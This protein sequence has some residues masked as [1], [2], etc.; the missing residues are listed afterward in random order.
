MSA[1]KNHRTK[2]LAQ[3]RLPKRTQEVSK[4]LKGHVEWL[5]E[6]PGLV[7]FPDKKENKAQINPSAPRP[8][9][10]GIAFL[11]IHGRKLRSVQTVTAQ[12]LTRAPK[13]VSKSN[14][15]PLIEEN[16]REIGRPSSG[17]K[18]KPA[19]IFFGDMDDSGSFIVR[20]GSLEI[21]S[22]PSAAAIENWKPVRGFSDAEDG[23]MF[24]DI[25]KEMKLDRDV[26]YRQDNRD[27]GVHVIMGKKKVGRVGNG[28]D[29]KNANCDAPQQRRQRNVID[30]ED[31]HQ[32]SVSKASTFEGNWR[33]KST[34]ADEYS[35]SDDDFFETLDLESIER[36]AVAQRRTI[37]GEDHVRKAMISNP[38][39]V[40]SSCSHNAPQSATF[41]SREALVSPLDPAVH[42]FAGSE[43]IQTISSFQESG[44]AEMEVELGKLERKSKQDNSAAI[45]LL[46]HGRDIP[47][48]MKLRIRKN[49][50]RIDELRQCILSFSRVVSPP[51]EDVVIRKE[52]ELNSKNSSMMHDKQLQIIDRPTP[53]HLGQQFEQ[54]LPYENSSSPKQ[55]NFSSSAVSSIH[56]EFVA[57][58]AYSS[59]DGSNANNS[60]IYSSHHTDAADSHSF[61]KAS[62][63]LPAGGVGFDE[64][65]G[66]NNESDKELHARLRGHLVKHFGFPQFRPGQLK[67]II[68]AMKGKDAFS[69]MPTGQGKSLC[70]QLPGILNRGVTIVISPLLSLVQDQVGS[71]NI[72]MGGSGCAVYLNSTQ[73]EEVSKEIYS[74]L[75]RCQ[76]SFKFLF[77]TPEKVAA[78]GSFAKALDRMTQA[79]LLA[80]VVIDEA[81]CVSQWG[82]DY[83]PDYLQLSLF[84]ERYPSVPLLALT[85]TATP[86][87]RDDIVRNLRMRSDFVATKLSFNR[88]NLMYEVRSKTSHGKVLDEIA[89]L[90]KQKYWGKC[91]IVYC[92]SRKNCEEV[93]DGLNLRLGGNH[94]SFYHAELDQ[95]VRSKRHHDWSNDNGIRIMCATIAFGMGINKPDV[96]F[97]MHYSLPKSPTHYYQESGRAGRDGEPADCIIFYSFGDRTILESMITQDRET[98]RLRPMTE[99]IRTQVENLNMMQEYCTNEVTCR[100]RLLIQFFG[101]A[102]EK[103]DSKMCICDNC[104][105]GNSG[106]PLENFTSCAMDLV[107]MAE[108]AQGGTILQII[109]AYR[110]AADSS[111]KKLVVPR[112]LI[113]KG[114]KHTRPV[115]EKVVHYLIMKD[116]LKTQGK[117]CGAY[118]ITT[119]TTSRQTNAFMNGRSGINV[120]LSRETRKA[121]KRNGDKVPRKGKTT[122]VHKDRLRKV[123]KRNKNNE[124]TVSGDASNVPNNEIIVLDDADKACASTG[125]ELIDT[126]FLSPQKQV[127]NRLKSS[128]LREKL[129]MKLKQLRKKLARDQGVG[130]HLIFANKALDCMARL[131]PA[132]LNHL[133]YEHFVL[134]D[135][136]RERY[137]R[138][139]LDTISDFISKHDLVP[140]GE[141]P[142]IPEDADVEK[143][144]LLSQ[145]SGARLKHHSPRVTRIKKEKKKIPKP[146]REI[147]NSSSYF[148][149]GTKST[150]NNIADMTHIDEF[151]DVN[152][153][154]FM[155]DS[156]VFQE[157]SPTK[158]PIVKRK[159]K[160]FVELDERRDRVVLKKR[161]NG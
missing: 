132:T 11:K 108:S 28:V 14:R 139:I 38:G 150:V 8:S 114:K 138:A 154:E 12:T 98:R 45:K 135:Q 57:E 50:L 75:F 116:I 147:N 133:R 143:V 96:R 117:K 41:L 76:V 85:A 56:N 84:R 131:L 93:S 145:K 63:N 161:K 60:L 121:T 74:Q 22:K 129:V 25:A 107:R 95:S 103:C 97:V 111:K 91:G 112:E 49:K 119:L 20:Q 19:D 23:G 70:Y 155:D 36:D 120:L 151:D 68:A 115:L 105:S 160:S 61:H 5:C 88:P 82:H 106:A 128:E 9:L 29:E 52:F 137:G 149:S 123:A 134:G 31:L 110:G 153:D 92:L 113:G 47:A 18:L 89:A 99:S 64:T 40:R 94:V 48:P 33:S 30:I 55:S 59:Y 67:T 39:N 1:E 80:R 13:E 159:I 102:F 65:L 24:A 27:H 71:I 126:L 152:F 15:P 10:S 86:R 3:A 87:V 158:K 140:C 2:A 90:I 136:K 53:N 157:T 144:H 142:E 130:I 26:A 148:R 101:D 17:A 79:N 69:I 51:Y 58:D 83:R 104:K 32:F 118:T 6:A 78:S 7:L 21:S 122:E 35:I 156:D 124:T 146:E 125:A 81:H 37:S 44:L 43:G 62:S 54:A 46:E 100:R 109:K 77:V 4:S 42:S 72:T 141:F 66:L 16:F 127:P 34:Y 73:S